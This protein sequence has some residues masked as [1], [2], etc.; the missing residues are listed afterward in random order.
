MKVYI[1]K[2]SIQGAWL[3]ILEGFKNAW[4][5]KGY[6]TYYFDNLDELEND[7]NNI[8]MIFDWDLHLKNDLHLKIFQNSYK[9]YLFVQPNN[10]PNPWGLHPNF[11]SCLDQKYIHKLNSINNIKKWTIFLQ[12]KQ[13]NYF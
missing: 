2:P 3:W 13:Y 12:N 9:T 5:Y 11:I 10:F 1:K 8:I 6:D 7:N 4:Q